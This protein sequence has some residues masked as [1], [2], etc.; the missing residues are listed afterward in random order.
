MVPPFSYFVIVGLSVFALLGCG[1][2]RETHPQAA[3]DSAV[4]I[5]ADSAAL[6]A[7]QDSARHWLAFRVDSNHI[8]MFFNVADLKNPPTEKRVAAKEVAFDR[9]VELPEADARA[10]LARPSGEHF[11]IGDRYQLSLDSG[12]VTTVTVTAF[13]GGIGMDTNDSWIGAVA[14]MPP[15]LVRYFTRDVYAVSRLASMNSAAGQSAVLN[16]AVDATV[17]ARIT[18]TVR[19]AMSRVRPAAV[20]PWTFTRVDIR[21][22]RLANGDL[23]Y[24]AIGVWNGPGRRDI[25]MFVAWLDDAFAIRQSQCSCPLGEAYPDGMVNVVTLGPGKTGMILSNLAPGSF[26]GFTL[27]E[28]QETAGG[29]KWILLQRLG[30]GG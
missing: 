12:L 5:A 21:P 1:R 22:F 15:N 14:V 20:S 29:P 23:R 3:G 18:D 11:D 17:R 24:H 25:A 8:V 28:Y 10:V 2:S 27:Y 26:T 9:V 4:A 19:N 13:A 16:T 6:P 30:A 7:A